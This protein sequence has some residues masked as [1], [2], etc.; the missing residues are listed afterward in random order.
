VSEQQATILVVDDDDAMTSA[1]CEVLRQKGHSALSAQSGADALEII[2]REP[3][4]LLIS[5][6]RMTEMTGHQLQ[7]QLQTIAPDL[8]VV[9]ITAFGSIESAVESMKLGARDFITKP[10]SNKELLLVVSRALENRRL[11]QE[12]KQLRGELARTYGLPNIIA[13]DPKMA[14]ILEM[15]ERVADSPATVLITGES[16]TGKDLL[17]RS[18]HFSSSRRDGPFV[19]VNCAALPE[20]L[21][22]SE[23]F[24][25][26]RGAFTDARQARAG[27]FVAARGGTLFLDEIGEMPIQ[28]QSKLL[29]TIE[30]KK[31]RPLGATEEIPVDVRIVAATNGDLEKAIEQGRFR[32]DLY[33]RLA[34]VTLAVPALR[35]RP[36]DI[37]L[38]IKHFLSRASAEAARPVPGIEPQ[39]MARLLR[40]PWPGNA[41][42]LQNAIQRGVLL[43]RDNMLTVKELPPKV[44]GLEVSPGKMLGEAVDKRISLEQLEYEY[45]RA[46]LDSVNGNKTEAANILRIDRKTLYRKLGESSEHEATG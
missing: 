27:L 30:D 41:R 24:G 11:R 35:D 18:L 36:D 16:G 23:L 13:A 3:L 19:P 1:V 33:Y 34:T 7:L 22:E 32:S 8:P 6:L 38:L 46:V 29:R 39:A 26:A 12:V 21:I 45:I 9:I 28:L 25:Y 20:N 15:V 44:A 4:D 42:E 5:D 40:Y 31:I 14:A 10:F 43:A 2:R 17:A 37:P